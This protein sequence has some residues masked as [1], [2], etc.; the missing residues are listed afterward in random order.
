M[1]KNQVDHSNEGTSSHV[2]WM[3]AALAVAHDAVSHGEVPIGA[4]VV[5][6]GKIIAKA[7][8]WRE[9][10]RDPTAH[11]E[12]LAIQAASQHLGG[13]RL[14]ECTLYVTLEPCPMCAGAIMLSRL[15]HV[16]FG[17]LDS[18]GGALVSKLELFS[19]QLWNHQP[20]VTGGILADECG[21]ILKDFFRGL[22][23]S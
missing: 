5:H 13:W 9:T 23:L 2:E 18:K 22:R 17:A 4:I 1:S 19:N 15:Q 10:W 6:E 12:L 16:Y 21:I 11:A 7:H 8:N 14:S 20:G 3:K